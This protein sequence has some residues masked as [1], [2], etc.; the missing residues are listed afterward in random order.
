ML[1]VSLSDPET[2]ESQTVLV[3]FAPGLFL[4]LWSNKSPVIH[5]ESTKPAG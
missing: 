4:S 3:L 2:G 5:D 1:L